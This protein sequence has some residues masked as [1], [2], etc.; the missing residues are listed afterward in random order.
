MPKQKT[1]KGAAKRLKVSGTGKIRHQNAWR[2]HNRNKRNSRRWRRA[3]GM[4]TL[5]GAN[6]KRMGRLLGR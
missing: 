4:S 6:E 1:H 5:D 2:V 3:K